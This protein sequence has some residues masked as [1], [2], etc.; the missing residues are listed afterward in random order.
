MTST[1]VQAA[2]QLLK[3]LADESRLR[4]LG[5]L[6]ARE[7]SVEELSALLNLRAPTVSHHLSLLRSLDL[8][9]V[10]AE[11]NVHLYRLQ[12]NVLQDRTRDLFSEQRV[13][14]FAD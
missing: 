4:I 7:H 11:G 5:L 2:V 1:T 14:S 8:V 6:A 3:A 13:A 9:A 12:S 10:R